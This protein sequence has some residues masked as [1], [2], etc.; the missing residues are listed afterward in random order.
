M[1]QAD[2]IAAAAGAAIEINA[3]DEGT[4]AVA[5]ANNSDAYFSHSRKVVRLPG[6]TRSGKVQLAA[7]LPYQAPLASVDITIKTR[8]IFVEKEQR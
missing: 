6:A 1:H 3:L 5:Y 2:S 4:G 7:I 8:G